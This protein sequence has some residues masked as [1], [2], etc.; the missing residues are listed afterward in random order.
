MEGGSSRKI[1]EV[2]IDTDSES[3]SYTSSEGRAGSGTEA[4]LTADETVIEEELRMH[5]TVQGR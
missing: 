4:T 5:K 2:F 1:V 3:E